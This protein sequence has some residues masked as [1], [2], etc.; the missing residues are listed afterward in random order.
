MID[1][2]KHEVVDCLRQ[3]LSSMNQRLKMAMKGCTKRL[4][5]VRS[6]TSPYASVFNSQNLTTCTPPPS[7]PTNAIT[8]SGFETQ[9]SSGCHQR[10]LQTQ[11]TPDLPRL[12]KQSN[13]V[14]EERPA[15]ANEMLDE[16]T[17]T[18]FKRPLPPN[19]ISFTSEE[20]KQLFREALA[21]KTLENYFD[22]AG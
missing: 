3:G 4:A 2:R 13:T 21:D 20:G 9:I 16:M 19:L 11:S 14:V 5:C 7:P 15:D 10:F 22:L 18:Y 12:I 6:A 1:K 8:I 17:T